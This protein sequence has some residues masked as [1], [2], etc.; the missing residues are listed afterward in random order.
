MTRVSREAEAAEL[1]AE[2]RGCENPDTSP[3]EMVDRRRPG[4]DDDEVE[5]RAEPRLPGERRAPLLLR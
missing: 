3:R 2:P 4:D 1:A 5:L